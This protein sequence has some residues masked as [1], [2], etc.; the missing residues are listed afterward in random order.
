VVVERP[1]ERKVQVYAFGGWSQHQAL[2]KAR[3]ALA[4]R[5]AKQWYRRRFGIESS[6]RQ[7]HQWQGRTT[8]TD[9]AYRLL[10]VGVALLL[11]QVWVWLTWQLARS[12]AARPKQWLEE[13]PLERMRDWLADVLQRT[14]PEAKAIPLTQPL[15]LEGIKR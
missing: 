13:L 6:Y 8:A 15:P 11:R 9:G 4:A 7:M 1:G 10:V 14:Y 12:R 3:A 5:Q 2:A